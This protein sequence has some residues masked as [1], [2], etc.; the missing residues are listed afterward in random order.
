MKNIKGFGLMALLF[1]S[2]LFLASCGDT[3][4]GDCDSA[5]QKFVANDPPDTTEEGEEI[6]ECVD[7]PEGHKQNPND[8]K[9][10]CV[11]ADPA[12]GGGDGSGTPP[13]KAL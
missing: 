10:D 9:A 4:A 12:D 13:P 5:S 6:G 3:T 2:L 11:P 7:C 1:G 8:P